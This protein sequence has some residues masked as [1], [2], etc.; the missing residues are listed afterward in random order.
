MSRTYF[1]HPLSDYDTQ[2]E[3][4][5]L[6]YLKCLGHDVTNPNQKRHENAYRELVNHGRGDAFEYFT[7]LVL[8]CDAVAFVRMPSGD[9]SAGVAKE[10]QCALE[11]GREVI[12]VTLSGHGGLQSRRML[13]V[14]PSAVLSIEDTRAQLKT[15]YRCANGGRPW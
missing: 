13:S 5:V 11:H 10:V 1:A 4:R 2:F 7:R 14:P 9:V 15:L 8:R 3:A 6:G 12:E